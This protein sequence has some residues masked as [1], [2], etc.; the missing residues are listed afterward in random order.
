MQSTRSTAIRTLDRS[1]LT[2]PNGKLADMVIESLA[3]R[4]NMR[5]H[6]VLGVTYDLKADRLAALR[7][8][9]AGYLQQHPRLWEG[10]APRCH[11]A[12]FGSSSLDIE[13]MAWF[14]ESD[15]DR[16][17]ELRH[18]VLIDVMRILEAHGAQVA[19]PTRTLH[20]VGPSTTQQS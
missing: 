4:D 20:I 6:L 2:I 11:F 15:W 3:A 17:L 10:Q 16:F 19:F 1:L 13:I 8:A 7:A 14:S 5:L 9:L 18:D 12:A